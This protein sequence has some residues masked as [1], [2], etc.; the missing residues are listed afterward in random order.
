M[1]VSDSEAGPDDGDRRN[2]GPASG[3]TGNGS[4][5]GGTEHAVDARTIPVWRWST[6]L[7]F[8]PPVTV[9]TFLFVAM[10]FAGAPIVPILWV[11]LPL[12]LGAMV[13]MTWWYPA[14]R[15]RHLRYRVDDVGITIR[16]GVLWRT[17]STLPRVRIQ[18]TDVSQGPLQRR[19]GV[20]T[21]KLYTAGSRFTRTE[22]PGLEYE[23][24]VAL[25]DRLQ[26]EGLGDAV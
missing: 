8:A 25:R 22:L 15:Y 21:L 14:A 13:L 19:Y 24:A 11:V 12:L 1:A 18:H 10:T 3:G 4:P 5:N 16:D 26:R 23:Q 6:A 7:S 2:G 17:Q 9:V 20:A